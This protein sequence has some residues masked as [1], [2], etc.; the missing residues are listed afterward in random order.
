[1]GVGTDSV[2][3]SHLE[4]A[5]GGGSEVDSIHGACRVA[6]HTCMYF[7]SMIGQHVCHAQIPGP[8]RLTDPNRVRDARPYTGTL[9]LIFFLKPNWSLWVWPTSYNIIKMS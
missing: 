9:Y 1:M 5:L 2:L 4:L 6:S 8:T 3:I 7:F